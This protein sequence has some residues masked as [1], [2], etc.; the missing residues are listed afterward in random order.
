MA[1]TP[2]CAP[3]VDV[4]RV[5]DDLCVRWDADGLAEAVQITL[6]PRLTHNFGHCVADTGRITIAA[7]LVDFPAILAEVVAHEVAHVEVWR[8][9]GPAARS[10]GSRWIALMEQ[11]GFP[12]RRCLPPLPG[13]PPPRRQTSRRY[14]HRCP[15][16]AAQRV[17]G[18][19][20]GRWR[21]VACFND[22]RDGVLDIIRVNG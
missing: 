17:G 5:V 18:R 10:H 14:L 22:G 12:A 7:R 13:D 3:A 11:A 2:A 20:V 21:C 19:P 1:T 8:R 9:H 16:C 6:S 4:A 15:T